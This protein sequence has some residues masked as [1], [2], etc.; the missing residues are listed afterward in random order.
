[1]AK[2]SVSFLPHLKTLG[3]ASSDLIGLFDL[4]LNY[5]YFNPAQ[6]DE[7]RRLYGKA[8]ALNEPVSSFISNPEDV[9]K[10]EALWKRVLKGEEFELEAFFGDG[11]KYRIHYSPIYDEEEIIGGV[12]VA[13]DISEIKRLSSTLDKSNKILDTFF[14]NSPLVMG[15]V[16]V[17]D[18]DI[19][20]IADNS[21]AVNFFGLNPSGKW[22][23]AELGIPEENINLWIRH[24]KKAEDTKRPVKF[25][26]IHQP[27]GQRK[28][29]LQITV[30][31]LGKDETNENKPTF[32]YLVE[33]I[34]RQEE[35]KELKLLSEK[36]SREDQFKMLANSITQLAWMADKDGN[37]YW[38]N[39]RWF[40]YTG[41]TL[42]EM[43]VDGWE[44]VV[45]PDHLV[46]VKNAWI[47]SV[48]NKSIYEVIIPIKGKTEEW[49]WFL[50]RAV[51][52]TGVNQE[53]IWFGTNTD[54]HEQKQSFEEARLIIDI[55]PQGIWRTDPGGA[56][57]Y[58]SQKFVQM[59]GYT[60]EE[61]GEGKWLNF[62][63]PEDQKFV[64]IEWETARQKKAPVKVE[65]RFRNKNGTV[66]WYLSLGNPFFDQHGNLLF[67]YGTWTDITTQKEAQQRI[68][69]QANITKT[70]TDNAASCL[71]MMDKRGH[72]TFMNPAATTVTGYKSLDEIKN[73]PLHY[74]IHW[75]KPDGSHYPIEACPID[76]ARTEIRP[77]REKE[78]MFCTKDGTLFP[79][80]FSIMPLVQR[81]EVVGSVLEFRDISEEKRVKESL[82]RAIQARDEFL[83]LASHELKTPLTSLRLSTQMVSRTVIKNQGVLSPEKMRTYLQ[84]V[85]KDT[86]RLSKLVDDMLDIS[87][88][89]TGNLTVVK[90]ET[91]LCEL[92]N[93]LIQRMG[94]EFLNKTGSMPT[95]KIPDRC[96]GEWDKVRIEQL[97]TNLITN[98]L[99]YGQGSP[100][101][102]EIKKEKDNKVLLSVNDQ[103]MGI[104]QDKQEII[105]ERFE[106]AGISANEIS[107]M[108]LGLFISKQI[109]LAHGGK[110]W[111]ESEPRKGATFF[112][113]LPSHE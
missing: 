16:E 61:L 98:A 19:F 21:A 108:G 66:S 38:Y 55:I 22:A 8:P 25:N 41:T 18:D 36:A 74:S 5:L 103:G 73:K 3:N 99:R 112:V 40:E 50:V 105:F 87:R 51:K 58:V 12:H 37:V 60:I 72:P 9:A 30:S 34:T 44:K 100:V 14:H 47:D 52:L 33:D 15:V 97:L 57:D 104:P 1:M 86:I 39:D 4:N 90:E 59:T 42:E 10:I 46:M 77:V 92:T 69:Y 6:A 54:I 29:H 7:C 64:T 93:D 23:R 110:I 32:A 81:G 28:N 11:N 88:I 20:H 102:I 2:K 78:E 24:Y 31:F 80:S 83:S 68:D 85:D 101:T 113:E 91:D 56:A 82:Y 17:T 96:M 26:Y 71:F 109:V 67:Y 43:V 62:V 75:K 111:V 27:P 35:A 45:H 89:R 48:K 65:F 13:K 70:I 53:T 84:Q 94:E 63:L 106:R 49:R 95:L 107:G 76:N 79:V